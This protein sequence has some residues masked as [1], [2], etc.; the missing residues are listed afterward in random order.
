VG[1]HGGQHPTYYG[2][3]AGGEFQPQQHQYYQAQQQSSQPGYHDQYHH[4][5]PGAAHAA[6]TKQNGSISHASQPGVAHSAVGS[7]MAGF[8]KKK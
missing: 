2:A 6:Y 7:S 3:P 5:S 4:Q 1:Q 8:S